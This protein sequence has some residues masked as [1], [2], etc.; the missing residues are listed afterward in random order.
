[1]TQEVAL[2]T[3]RLTHPELAA[4]SYRQMTRALGES[5]MVH[6]DAGNGIT[7]AP[8]DAV[9]FGPVRLETSRLGDIKRFATLPHYDESLG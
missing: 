6:V 9:V 3:K 7:I 5:G 2:W 1:M 8:G 4:E